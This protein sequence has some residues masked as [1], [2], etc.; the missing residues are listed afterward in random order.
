ML[1]LNILKRNNL[2]LIPRH[3]SNLLLRHEC[4]IL[5][6]IA[7]L[8]PLL[9][10][11]LHAPL[12]SHEVTVRILSD[13]EIRNLTVSRST[14]MSGRVQEVVLAHSGTFNVPG[15]A[16]DQPTLTDFELLENQEEGNL[17]DTTI[18]VSTTVCRR[19]C[20]VRLLQAEGTDDR[21]L[22]SVSSIKQIIQSLAKDLSGPVERI[23]VDSNPRVNILPAMTCSS[24][25][26]GET[27]NSQAILITGPSG[28]GKTHTA[29]SIASRTHL[30]R[31]EEPKYLDCRRLRD[32]GS[33]TMKLILQTIREVFCG[34]YHRLCV[35]FDNIEDICPSTQGTD[36]SSGSVQ[37]NAV[38]DLAKTEA[39]TIVELILDCIARSTSS[40]L[41]FT[42]EAEESVSHS[43]ITKTSPRVLSIPQISKR[44]RATQFKKILERSLDA[45][46]PPFDSYVF[47]KLAEGYRPSDVK[48]FALLTAGALT[49]SSTLDTAI[50][51]TAA[52]FVPSSTSSMP[53]EHAEYV[54]AKAWESVGG[55]FKAK[56]Q[57]LRYVLKP[58]RFRKVYEASQTRLPKGVLL[59]GPSGYGKSFLVPALARE[60]GYNLVTCRGPELL[61]KFI[62]ASEANVR[63]LFAR[64]SDAAPSILF[65]D[66][67]DALAPRRGSDHTGVTDRI[68][69]QLLTFLDGV[70]NVSSKLFVLAATSRP[71]RVDPA[72]LRPG[73]LDKHVYIGA[74]ESL[75]E[76]SHLLS[77]V[78]SDFMLDSD[79]VQIIKSGSFLLE[80]AKESPFPMH[81]SGADLKGACNRAQVNAIKEVGV[82]QNGVS[83]NGVFTV[84]TATLKHSLRHT[85]AALSVDEYQELKQ[86]LYAPVFS[87][88]DSSSQNRSSTRVNKTH[89]RDSA[90]LTALR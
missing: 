26:I 60:C 56:E 81:M 31:G 76:A 38:H 80:L 52:S 40:S 83:T 8:H 43:L 84:S 34:S 4:K 15:I 47:G 18:I 32:E 67:I 42:A 62:G 79:L 1:I 82:S 35:V 53:Q 66:E 16:I 85:Q 24:C 49:A 70:E 68:V 19:Q 3:P 33:N 17:I 25:S 27:V 37:Q 2:Q 65:L 50:E 58:S 89:S 10:F 74:S 20:L 59:F 7:A 13:Q 12:F 45:P 55:L 11:Q 77:K 61:D 86:T 5:T 87:S 23:L 90:Q 30:L 14:F 51:K 48:R 44:D 57:L 39:K 21:G 63:E 72:L 46:V 29:L 22:I 78:A 88:R 41:I 36:D 71:E 73:R 6:I 64:A 9:R 28:C 54:H 75:E 69:N